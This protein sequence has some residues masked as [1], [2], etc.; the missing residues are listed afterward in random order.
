MKISEN[1]LA[2]IKR[3][4]GC[5]LKAYQDC[6]GVWTIGWGITNA[7]KAITGT[8]IKRGLTISKSTAEDWLRKSIN[9]KYAPMVAK[10]DEH[11]H[12][13][14]NEFDALVSF[15]YNVGSI[16]ELTAK[17]KRTRGEIEAAI[18]RYCK[19]R[20]RVVQGLRERRAAELA[21]FRKYSPETPAGNPYPEP[22]KTVTSNEQATALGLKHWQNH[23]DEVKAVQW[24]LV[25]LGYSIGAVDGVCG[26]KT[27]TG[28]LT[29]QLGAGL[30]V[31]GA[32]GTQTWAALKAAKEKPKASAAPKVERVNYRER[33]A[34]AGMEVYPLCVGKKHGKGVQKRVK[35]LEEFKKQGELNCH[36]MLSLAFQ[37]AGLLPEGCFVTHTPKGGKKRKI[38]D[39]VKGTEK[40]L[41]CKVYWAN[42][43]WKDLPEEWQLPGVGY[44]QDSNACMKSTVGTKILS[45]NKDVGKEYEDEGDYLKDSGY[46]KT[47]KV[48]V[49]IVPDEG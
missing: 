3:F 13:S 5:S 36:L 8:T 12:W 10:Y 34:K 22:T 44:I 25:R 1:G 28:I 42:K 6:V 17:G 31:D 11:F 49:V 45:C 39:A 32:C 35:N 33:S 18:P 23:G 14:Q 15:A 26:K 29:F 2:L 16:E 46:V 4:E 20:G 21:L 27:I 41:H 19:A 37:Q 30:K 47:S 24:E 38:T 48:L 7:D 43:L 9:Q 40:L